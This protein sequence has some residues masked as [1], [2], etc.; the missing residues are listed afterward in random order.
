MLLEKCMVYETN[1]NAL[2]R[3]VEV[4]YQLGLESIPWVS[5][6]CMPIIEKLLGQW[7]EC[8]ARHYANITRIAVHRQCLSQNSHPSLGQLNALA[9]DPRT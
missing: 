7:E 8:V 3:H 5:V 1:V 4:L 6:I 9:I 2:C